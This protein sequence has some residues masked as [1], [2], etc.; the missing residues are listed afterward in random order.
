[1]NPVEQ[2]KRSKKISYEVSENPTNEYVSPL[3][4]EGQEPSEE[5]SLEKVRDILFGAQSREFEERCSLLE[6]R[7]LQESTDLRDQL[8][9]S[10]EDIKTYINQEVSCLTSQ[11]QQE[12]AGRSSSLEEVG[13]VIKNVNSQL[14]SRLSALQDQT[15]TQHQ[16]LERQLTQQKADLTEHHQQALAGL[17]SRFQEA[18]KELK[19]EKTDRAALAELL[20]DVALRL[21]VGQ[22]DTENS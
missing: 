12:K 19:A 22:R 3:K 11:I 17:Q 5:G 8:T 18:F 13:Q 6:K 4:V 14:E 20:M 10:L 9:R 7:L 21:K 16:M 2:S 15:T 1:M